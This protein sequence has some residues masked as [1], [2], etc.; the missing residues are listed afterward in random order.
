MAQYTE[1]FNKADSSTLG[2]DL[3]WTEV[4]GDTQIVSNSVRPVATATIGRNRAEHDC[5]TDDNFAQIS[6]TNLAQNAG[7]VCFAYCRYD[8]ASDTS[9]GFRRIGNASLAS[10]AGQLA[11]IVAG[12]Q[13]LLGSAATVARAAIGTPET[14]YVSASGSTITGKIDGVQQQ[15]VTDTSITTGKR[16]GFGVRSS[17][18]GVAD[19]QA[20]NFASGDLLITGTAAIAGSGAIAA[21]GV[22][23]GLGTATITGA[24]AIAAT[25]L[26]AIGGSAAIAGAG[27]IA[28]TGLRT[29]LGTAAITGSGT[30][31]A[32][33]D[34]T[35]GTPVETTNCDHLNEDGSLNLN[36]DGGIALL[37]GCPVTAEPTGGGYGARKPD[38]DIP[39][40]TRDA[41]TRERDHNALLEDEDDEILILL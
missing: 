31:S 36:E 32:D 10:Y 7:N 19:C 12:T 28:A 27:I 35:S 29:A 16:A 37:E 15:Q 13:T 5:A 39:Q 40:R 11:K 6:S 30:I 24:G 21:T 26:V 20:D 8:S 33:G 14:I 17:A 1:S 23:T 41:W 34:V 25:G 38:W 3:T 9:Y 2:P 22:R 4:A 18:T